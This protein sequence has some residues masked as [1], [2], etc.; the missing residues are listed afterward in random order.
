MDLREETFRMTVVL[1][2]ASLALII[3]G[4]GGIG[5]SLAL[6]ALLVV[7]AGLL[8]VVALGVDDGPEVL[9]HDLGRYAKVLWVGALIAALLVVVARDATPGELQALG[10]LVGLLGMVNYFLRPVYRLAYALLSRL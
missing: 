9:G 6:A 10:G 3:A 1:V 8:S 5:G 2:A 7:V 4:A